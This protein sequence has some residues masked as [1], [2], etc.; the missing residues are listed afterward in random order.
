[1]QTI[2]VSHFD[3]FNENMGKELAEM[4]KEFLSLE[5]ANRKRKREALGEALEGVNQMDTDAAQ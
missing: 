4:Q 3:T 5:E 1:M 2:E